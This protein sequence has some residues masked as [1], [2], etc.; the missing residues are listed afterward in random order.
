[1]F[2]SASRL[3]QRLTLCGRATVHTFGRPYAGSGSIE[4]AGWR[5]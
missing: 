5:E 4:P 1:M 2:W 3:P